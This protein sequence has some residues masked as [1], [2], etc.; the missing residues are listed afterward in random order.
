MT[1]YQSLATVLLRVW[2]LLTIIGGVQAI[3]VQGAS[4]FRMFAPDPDTDFYFWSWGVLNITNLAT[5]VLIWIFAGALARRIA[6]HSA[7]GK[8]G[9]PAV[10]PD[11]LAAV[12][13]FLIGLYVIA[14][15]FP[16]TLAETINVLSRRSK[17]ADLAGAPISSPYEV[18]HLSGQW[19]TVILALALILASPR[20]GRF[21]AWLRQAGQYREKSETGG[22]AGK[23]AAGE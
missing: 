11:L 6:P 7:V 19:L 22:G 5:A 1:F 3:G 20:L 16:K 17:E 10:R 4:Y 18:L 13:A 8:D 14:Q 23:S 9:L 2:A 21:F 12:G 15:S